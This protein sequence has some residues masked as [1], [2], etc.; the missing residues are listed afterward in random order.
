MV[1]GGGVAYA[2]SVGSSGRVRSAGVSMD[3]TTPARSSEL[4]HSAGAHD[5]G[6]RGMDRSA[7]I[8]PGQ[9]VPQY[10]SHHQSPHERAAG[11]YR[12]VQSFSGQGQSHDLTAV[13]G[14]ARSTGGLTLPDHE[15]V[16]SAES[17]SNHGSGMYPRQ[18]R[19]PGM[20]SPASAGG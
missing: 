14:D 11:R 4:D 10:V 7:W 5:L 6:M 12:S 20:L 15:S 2:R 9:G 3:P 18:H 19:E 1:E 16:L 17:G 13:R 8:E